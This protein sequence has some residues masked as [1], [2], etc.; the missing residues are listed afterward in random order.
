M[1]RMKRVIL[2]L[3]LC[4]LALLHSASSPVSAQQNAPGLPTVARFFVQNRA[5]GEAIPIFVQNIQGSDVLP[6]AVTN[7]PVVT[8]VPNAEIGARQVR[9]VWEYR[10]LTAAP[11][12]NAASALNSLGAD[13]WEVVSLV[14]ATSQGTTWLLKRPRQ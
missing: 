12:D 7:A 10:Q 3:S 4:T 9:Q 11:G 2:T 6:V 5:R 14:P 8:L 1:L 13:G